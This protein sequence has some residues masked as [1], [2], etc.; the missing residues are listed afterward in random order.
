MNRRM[1]P[2]ALGLALLGTISFA[3]VVPED[4]SQC[5][6][7][8]VSADGQAALGQASVPD[9]IPVLV[10]LSADIENFN[11]SDFEQADYSDLM[12]TDS[13]GNELPYEVEVW[14]PEGESLVWVRIPSLD[15][16]TTFDAYFGG[17]ANSV[18]PTQVWTGYIGVWHMA[19]A[20]GNALDATGHELHGVPTGA[21]A[22]GMVACEGVIGNGRVNL[23]GSGSAWLTVPSYTAY[24]TTPAQFTFSGWFYVKKPNGCA[25]NPRFV[26][27][28]SKYD[29]K[30]GWE[31]QL[32]LDS[33]GKTLGPRGASGTKGEAKAEDFKNTWRYLVCV[34]DGSTVY[35]YQ[36]NRSYG[37]KAIAAATDNGKVLHIG[38][39]GVSAKNGVGKVDENDSLSGNYDEIRLFS[40]VMSADHVLADYLTSSMANFFDLSV[41]SM[42]ADVPQFAMPT[43]AANSDGT[44]TFSVEL[45]SGSG[46]VYAI[47]DNG[48]TA[49]TNLLAASATPG[50]YTDTPANLAANT[51]YTF[52][53]FGVSGS[54]ETALKT[55]G[56]FYNGNLVVE[57]L[58]DA[59]ECDLLPGMFRISRADTNGLLPITYTVGGTAVAD[60]TYVAL[61]GVASIPDGVSS[62]DIA[63]T[64]LEDAATTT[65]STVVLALAAGPYGS[66]TPAATVTVLEYVEPFVLAAPAV[67]RNSDGTYTL[68]AET[69]SGSGI[70]Y[71][72]YRNGDTAVTN[73]APAI[74]DGVFSDTPSELVAD[75][76]Y[77]SAAL[78][79]NAS[80]ILRETEGATF[81]T[82]ALSL[83]FVSDAREAGCVPGVVRFTRA[84]SSYDLAVSYTVGG[85][86]IPG[87]TYVA[88]PGTVVIPAGQTSVDLAVTP[89]PDGAV[90]SDSTVVLTLAPGPYGIDA[91][92]DTATVT[93][94]NLVAPTGY[95]TWVAPGN[96]LASDPA[97]WSLGRV[98]VSTDA[99]LLDG[100]YSS[101]DCEW[102]AGVNGLPDTVAS[103]TQTSGY[104]GAA[105]FDTEFESYPGASFTLFTVAGN[106]V[107]DSGV[108]THPVSL[109]QDTGNKQY[110]I[111]EMRQLARYRLRVDVGGTL[112]IGEDGAIDVSSKGYYLQV[113]LKNTD[114]VN[115]AHGGSSQWTRGYGNPKC[116]VDIGYTLRVKYANIDN[117]PAGGGAA[118]IV[119][120]GAVTVDGEIS[121][122]GGVGADNRGAAAG[123][124][125]LEA[126]SVAG[127]GSV[128]AN[129]RG[130]T[131]SGPGGRV[132]VITETPVDLATLSVTAT[133]GPKPTGDSVGSGVGTVY[134]FDNTSTNGT[135]RVVGEVTTRLGSDGNTPVTAESDWTFDA[136]VLGGAGR[137]SV[138]EGTTLTL[139]NGLASVSSTDDGSHTDGLVVKKDGTLVMGGVDQTL[140]GEWTFQSED[141]FTFPGNLAL[142][143]SAWLGIIRMDASGT[144]HALTASYTVNGD[145]FVATNCSVNV[146]EVF[147]NDGRNDVAGAYGGW[148][149]RYPVG[150]TNT[151]GSV[152]HPASIGSCKYA[153][154]DKFFGSG[155]LQ[156]TVLGTLAL[157]GTISASGT[158]NN[159]DTG[160]APSGGSLDIC[161][162]TLTGTGSI[163]ADGAEGRGGKVG[164][165]GGGRIA[166]RLTDPGATIP[167][168]IA[169]SA[170]GYHGNLLNQA[171]NDYSSSPGSI[172]LQPAGTPEGRGTLLIKGN[173]DATITATTPIVA[174]VDGD[175]AELF[176]QVP[177]VVGGSAIAEVSAPTLQLASLDVEEG[178]KI[179]LCGNTLAVRYASFGGHKLAP[180]SYH[181]AELDELVPGFV[182][183][184]LP[185]V[186]APVPT[187]ENPEPEP[188]PQPAPGTLTV[189]GDQTIILIR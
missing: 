97:N 182:L 174:Y 151:Y 139:P 117:I 100:R 70:A 87:Q 114:V 44:F 6:E 106:V 39:I 133:A 101:A 48:A 92:A 173:G 89:L 42:S 111:D 144:N 47:Y 138:T 22:A 29:N 157:D 128:H 77:L 113:E 30:D 175:S 5:I 186:P 161:A 28:K 8:T 115:S 181:A 132:A 118:Y 154:S 82:G 84:D 59:N 83:T 63:V 98:P 178:S 129:G 55:G 10:R 37:G 134:L 65:D 143:N 81:H 75:T 124:V 91:A 25:K 16:N 60:Q 131:R 41:S 4:F 79:V 109:Y 88:L 76:T 11:Y 51:T 13:E 165:G 137:L 152:L 27:R 67:V 43:V 34:Y 141:P 103:W 149:R 3:D 19:E 21:N 85:T 105:I 66:G 158:R 104:A 12:F 17:P 38:N 86:A 49:V 123:S 177:L 170:Y 15:A 153:K 56:V 54:G 125:Y 176:K 147:Y 31:I 35:V 155:A 122:D 136:V 162:G 52:T 99:I 130:S 61:S 90:S 18:D 53:A 46:D 146:G 20:G 183:D 166:V 119:S 167:D 187:E 69:A 24:N 23:S 80:G 135:L 145:L 169:I 185:V 142:T 62:V 64:P 107:I 40:G 164:G 26:S 72:I 180:G 95:N 73:P 160:D 68:T 120:T 2:T 188:P 148:S 71:A 78:G 14:N 110:S 159:S 156:L 9:G 45:T 32:A 150:Q 116:P 33:D 189:L 36:D 163:T 74:A 94:E 171:P 127:T 121:A 168:T 102:D 140:D 172:Y 108:W 1:L 57:A 96:G 184:T 7:F 50:T 93:I 126:P 179:D 112:S 58:A